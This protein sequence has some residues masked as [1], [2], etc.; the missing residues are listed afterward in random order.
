MQAMEDKMNTLILMTALIGCDGKDDTSSNADS[1]DAGEFQFTNTAVDDDCL[2]G[3]FT[4][5]F[6][7]EGDGTESDWAYPVELPAWNNLPATYSIQL[8]EPFSSMDITVTDGGSEQ[9]SMAGA[10]QAGVVFNEDSYPDCTVDLNI[11]ATINIETVD[12]VT[13]QA[14]MTVDS[15]SGDTCPVFEGGTPCQ[16]TLDFFGSRL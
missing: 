15:P 11:D 2:D 12:S 16:V 13:G 5:L 1:F 4:V 14:F 3:G 9:F 8:Q 10:L 7:P 6:L